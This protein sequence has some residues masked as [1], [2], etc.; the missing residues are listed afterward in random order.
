M[1]IVNDFTFQFATFSL[2]NITDLDA[3]QDETI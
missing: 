3:S 2:Y 1:K